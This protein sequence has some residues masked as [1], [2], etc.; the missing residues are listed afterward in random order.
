MY[1]FPR[2]KFADTNTLDSQWEH[3]RSEF[4][5]A[6]KAE[7]LG[8]RDEELMDLWH[9]IETY[10]RMRQVQGIDVHAVAAAVIKKN[11]LRG[12]YD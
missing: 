7:G 1:T 9:S 2:V 4:V 10:F 3:I 8:D 6:T 5:E 11:A 12:Y